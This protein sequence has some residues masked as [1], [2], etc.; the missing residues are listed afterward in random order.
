MMDNAMWTPWGQTEDTFDAPARP[1][2]TARVPDSFC[3]LVLRIPKEKTDVKAAIAD[4]AKRIVS[5]ARRSAYGK[6]EDNFERIAKFWQAFFEN[7]GRPEA[8][9]TAADVSP[10]MRLMKEAR[11]CETPDHRDSFV[12]LVGYALTGAEINKVAA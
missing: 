10:L 7:T 12:D 4:D 11:L 9:V 6:P 8:N 2:D 1:A 3:D 5:G